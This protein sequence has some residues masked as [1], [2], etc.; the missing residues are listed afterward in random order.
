MVSSNEGS[1][2]LQDQLPQPSIHDLPVELLSHI[3]SLSVQEYFFHLTRIQHL[4]LVCSKWRDVVEGTPELWCRLTGADPLRGVRKAIH[5]S[6]DYP[7]DINSHF[8][9]HLNGS[10]P[11]DFLPA[12]SLH[13]C[14]WKRASIIVGPGSENVLQ[15]ALTVGKAPRLESLT[16]TSSGR[17]KTPLTLFQGAVLPCL[18][19]LQLRNAPL[20]WN[21][22]QLFNLQKLEIS[23]EKQIP[24]P[25]NDVLSVLRVAW[26]LEEFAFV[27]SLSPG[28]DGDSITVPQHSILPPALK[29][30]RISSV[31]TSSWLHLF[32]TIR[33]P[34]CRRISLRGDL[35]GD[36][37]DPNNLAQ[38]AEAISQFFPC[39]RVKVDWEERIHI[40][41]GSPEV[42]FSLS[43]LDLEFSH[44][45]ER[46][47]LAKWMIL[48]FVHESMEV[49]L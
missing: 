17:M 28:V 35:F 34:A 13:A 29:K 5:Y 38:I 8:I 25:L 39:V 10:H 48:N 19:N 40:T 44:S 27:G 14:R 37:E 49:A 12:V 16:I 22:E 7:L 32:R 45:T 31:R 23:A 47:Q 36:L 1:P 9:S 30:L 3:V 26:G 21:G 24:P 6:R 2:D 43:T 46:L 42:R 15:E 11:N 4:C 41:V 18:R 33:A 20:V